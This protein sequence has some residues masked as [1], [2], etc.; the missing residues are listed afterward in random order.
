MSN[1]RRRQGR[2]RTGFV[3]DSD[4]NIRGPGISKRTVNMMLD[5]GRRF[6][7]EQHTIVEVRCNIGGLA[8][9]VTTGVIS[10]VVNIS[11]ANVLGL[12]RY[13]NAWDEYRIIEAHMDIIPVV[14]ST[15]ILRHWFDEQSST[16]PTVNESVE[17]DVYNQLISNG[18]KNIKTFTWKPRDIKDLQFISSSTTSVVA[19]FKT[20]TDNAN[21]GAPAA[22]TTVAVQQLRLIVEWRGVKST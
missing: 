5:D 14:T 21:W 11:T 18:F 8:T 10:N 1:S 20:Y 6:A 7:K 12:T 19:Y 3:R 9:T 17:R 22:A 16:A 4:V 2:A 15:G 13:T